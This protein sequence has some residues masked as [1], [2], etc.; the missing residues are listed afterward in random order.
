ML[1]VLLQVL[2]FFFPLIDLL[3]GTYVSLWCAVMLSF[4]FPVWTPGTVH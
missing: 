1:H 4:N 2:K 3:P